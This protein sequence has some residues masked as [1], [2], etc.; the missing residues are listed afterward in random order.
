MNQVLD[1]QKAPHY[2]VSF[3]NTCEEIDHVITAPHCI[4]N[5]LTVLLHYNL[6]WLHS[7]SAWHIQGHG[8]THWHMGNFNK[9]LD[10]WFPCS[11]KWLMAEKC[12]VRLLSDDF[13]WTSILTRQHWFREWLCAIRQQAISWTNVDQYLCHHMASLGHP[14]LRCFKS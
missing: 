5:Q 4:C 12:F 7:L 2:R 10:K 9:I 6:Y 14:E 3:V 13:K 11:L 1:S 8:F